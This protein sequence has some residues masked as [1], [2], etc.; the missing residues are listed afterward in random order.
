MLK[1]HDL[2]HSLISKDETIVLIRKINLAAKRADL[3]SLPYESFAQFM[4][5]LAVFC[6]SRPPLDLSGS[7]PLA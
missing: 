6:Y 4:L 3:G 1:D 2:L 5:Q 7:S